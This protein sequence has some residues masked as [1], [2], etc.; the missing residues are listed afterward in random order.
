MKKPA[1]LFLGLLAAACGAQELLRIV[2]GTEERT[3]VPPGLPAAVTNAYAA[4]L[5][6]SGYLPV[7]PVGAPHEDWCTRSL[8]TLVQTNGVWRETWI[9]CPV[10]VPL[11]RVKLCDVILARPDGT[12]ALAMAMSLPEVAEWFV[13]DPVYVRGSV[14]AGSMQVLLGAPDVSALEAV[15]RPCAA[16]GFAK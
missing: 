7:E 8:R 2:N 6:A 16:E 9:E 14:L 15:V 10:P 12:N 4:Q 11:D 13:S 3:I 1:L 5:A